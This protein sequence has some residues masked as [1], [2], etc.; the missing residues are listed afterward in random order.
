[1]ATVV[2][3]DFEWDERKAGDNVRKH[4]I[5][6]EE[7]VT[8]FFDEHFVILTDPQEHDDRFVLLGK[9]SEFRLLF[10]VHAQVVTHGGVERTR[11]ISARRANRSDT[12]KYKSGGA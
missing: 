6:F 10:V 4:G 1:M 3:D 8:A 9:S 12:K 7:A 11:L 5:T 2:H